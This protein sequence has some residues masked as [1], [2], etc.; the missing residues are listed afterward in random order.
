MKAF[1]EW[2]QTSIVQRLPKAKWFTRYYK[3]VK[4][5]QIVNLWKLNWDERI[6]D[7]MEISKTLLK[8]LRYINNEKGLV[9]ILGDGDYT[10]HLKFVDID[11]FSTSAQAKIDKPGTASKMASKTYHKIDKSLKP[12]WRTGR[13]EARSLKRKAEIAKSAKLKAESLKKMALKKTVAKSVEK[14]V[15]VLKTEK[16]AEPIKKIE[17]AKKIESM[18]K[19]AAKP[20]VKKPAVKK[21][22][23]AA[24]KPVTK[25][26]VVKKPK[27]TS[28]AKKP[29]VKK[30][31]SKKAK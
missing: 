8:Q 17:P 16:K 9:K 1:F 2:G 18:K 29:A 24:K 28:T 13:H 22:I 25:K 5:Y 31:A 30:S 4:D 11:A 21:A 23:P 26:S 6:T 3:L 19:E 15:E 14:K 20:E 7:T 10:K 27:T 12:A